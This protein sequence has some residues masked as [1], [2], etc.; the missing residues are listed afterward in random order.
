M[1]WMEVLPFLGGLIAAV[2]GG[3]LVADAALRD[4]PFAAERRR[5]PRAERSRVGQGCLGGSLVCTAL[6]LLSGGGTPFS[7]A[8]TFIGI[9]LL[10]AGVV[11][12]WRYLLDLINGPSGRASPSSVNTDPRQSEAGATPAYGW[13]VSSDD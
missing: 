10:T 13:P 9:A 5:T 11:L 8:A 6:V 1:S 3:A 2:V 12:N 7:I 4:E